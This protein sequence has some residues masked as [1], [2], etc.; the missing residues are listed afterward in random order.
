LPP[1]AAT[2]LWGLSYSGGSLVWW[3]GV[4][5][6]A[7][8][9][10][11]GSITAPAL[12]TPFLVSGG[13]FNDAPTAL[14]YSTNGGTGWSAAPSPVITANAYSFTV[15]GLAAGTYSIRVRDHANTAVVG[16]SNSFTIAAPTISVVSAPATV[17]LGAP[18]ALSGTVSPA[19]AAV[20][21]G[22][23]SSSSA[24][25]PS[26]VSAVVS[27]GAWSA[28]LTPATA[29]TFYFWA[30]QQAN[31]TVSAVSGA[32]LVVAAAIAVSAP[33]TGTVDIAM[34]ISGT[35]SPAVDA[36]NV[37][38]AVQNSAVPT[39]GWTTAANNAGSFTASLT[40][41]AGGTYYAWAQDPAT[42]L[43]A[44]SSSIV[45]AAAPAL[46]YGINNPGG[47]YVHGVSTIPLNGAV[48]PPQ[49]IAT[50]VALSTSNTTVPTSGWESALILYSNSL[51]GIYY[52][53]P[54]SAGNYY[55]WVE[56]AAGTN[57]T[58]SPF[59]IPVA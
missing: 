1:G 28:T 47:S 42:G 11:V 14:D 9:I 38:L 46:T 4:V 3:S 12:N 44:V 18:L 36:V 50:Q 10:T 29:G 48:N 17:E 27:D 16:A 5:P 21:V 26:W 23:T 7:P 15:A 41:A 53:T 56:T 25:P 30:E 6:N 34:A 58:V 45:V 40:A 52:T 55:V 51:W 49:N 57:A 20:Q 54:A 37:Q 19:N 35:V 2:T 39:S 24:A 31:P 32:I 13:V 43:S 33:A 59:T 8:T 22:I